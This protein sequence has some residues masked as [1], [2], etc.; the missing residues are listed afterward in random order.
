MEYGKIIQI[1]PAPP[2]MWAW[3]KDLTA[4]YMFPN[5]VVCM[6]LVENSMGCRTV[7]PMAIGQTDLYADIVEDVGFVGL[8]FM[9]MEVDRPDD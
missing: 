1:I 8:S 3:Y 7:R 9:P 5:R 2:D 4:G 6:A